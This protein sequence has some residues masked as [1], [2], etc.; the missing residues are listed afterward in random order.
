MRIHSTWRNERCAGSGGWRTDWGLSGE[1]LEASQ[2][3]YSAGSQEKTAG[4]GICLAVHTA[5]LYLCSWHQ[6]QLLAQ[7]DHPSS[8]EAERNSGSARHHPTSNRARSPPSSSAASFTQQGGLPSHWPPCNLGPSIRSPQRAVMDDWSTNRRDDP[9]L[10]GLLLP[11]AC[12]N[13]GP[14]IYP[15]LK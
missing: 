14:Q 5:G 9:T 13:L 1:T 2:A 15:I 6:P 11:H 8:K 12:S 3:L 4:P 10:G 7:R